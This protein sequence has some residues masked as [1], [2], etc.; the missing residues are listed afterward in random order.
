MTGIRIEALIVHYQPIWSSRIVGL[1]AALR[2]RTVAEGVES[3]E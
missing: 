2:T 3:W 1:A